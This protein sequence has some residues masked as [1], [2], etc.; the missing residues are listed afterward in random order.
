MSFWHSLLF[1]RRCSRDAHAANF[2]MLEPPAQ[3]H[4]PTQ[5]FSVF[6]VGL[7]WP[8]RLKHMRHAA[9][10]CPRYKPDWFHRAFSPLEQ[11][12]ES[13]AFECRASGFQ[14]C[15]MSRNCLDIPVAAFPKSDSL[16]KTSAKPRREDT[17][18]LASMH[19]DSGTTIFQSLSAPEGAHQ[20]SLNAISGLC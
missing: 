4:H 17:R 15:R 1:D 8:L 7:A 11:H 10:F 9:Y 5:K 12:H 18:D 13:G 14:Y 19:T 6:W 20:H 3:K 2:S 16:N